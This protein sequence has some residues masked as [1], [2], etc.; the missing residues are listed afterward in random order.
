MIENWLKIINLKQK[1]PNVELDTTLIFQAMHRE[2]ASSNN[3]NQILIDLGAH[4]L[5]TVTTIHTF[6]GDP[7]ASADDCSRTPSRKEL[8]AAAESLS[9]GIASFAIT[10]RKSTH[11]MEK[12]L[13]DFLT[14][15]IGTCFFTAMRRAETQKYSYAIDATM[16]LLVVSLSLMAGRILCLTLNP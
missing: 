8:V 16:Q 6:Y 3:S 4:V 5:K 11:K 2:K 7:K 12:M 14:A 9:F 13:T 10:D 15:I 1:L